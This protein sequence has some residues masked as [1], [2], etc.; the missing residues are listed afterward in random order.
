MKVALILS[1]LHGMDE[2]VFSIH[3][4]YFQNRQDFY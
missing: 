1:I 3:L 2:S 4:V